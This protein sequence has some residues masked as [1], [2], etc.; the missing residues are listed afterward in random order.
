[1]STEAPFSK[2]LK[3]ARLRSGL[4]QHE[5]G[6]LAGIDAENAS[7][8]MNQYE[9][10]VHIPKFPRLKDLAKALQVPTAYFYA[11]S[12]R[13]AELL[14][15]YESLSKKQLQTIESLIK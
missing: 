7:A 3:E 6:V 9:H 4:T 5:L 14:Y 15:E 12:P 13:L 2:R 10:G 1:M 11:E 8:K